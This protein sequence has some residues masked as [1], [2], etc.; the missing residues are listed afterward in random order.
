MAREERVDLIIMGAQGK[1]LAQEL[2]LGSV[3]HQVVRTAPVPVLVEKFDVVRSLGHVECRRCCACTFHMALHHTD[4][5]PCA[6]AAFQMVKR[7]RAAGTRVAIPLH[8]QDERVASGMPHRPRLARAQPH[9]R[10]LH[11]Q[12]L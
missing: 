6:H 5:S 8:V 10:T 7:L 9:R 2:L 4:F 1:S 3:A 11:G 12:H